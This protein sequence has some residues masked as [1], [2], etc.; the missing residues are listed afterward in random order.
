MHTMVVRGTLYLTLE[1]RGR[2]AAE[3]VI[4][5]AAVVG[6]VMWLVTETLAMGCE[7]GR[8]DWAAMEIG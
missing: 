5:W 7:V 4:K 3:V 2:A 8:K 1:V 6:L